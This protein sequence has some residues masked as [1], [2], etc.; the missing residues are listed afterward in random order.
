MPLTAASGKTW[1]VVGA[2]RGIGNEL[3][4][5]LLVNGGTVLATLRTDGEPS[6]LWPNVEDLG[7]RCKV[8][9]C[10]MLDKTSIDVGSPQFNIAA[11]L[12]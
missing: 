1:L 7:G 8:F 9:K 2:S 10:D 5:Q 11:R 3:V 6:K 4:R 12:T